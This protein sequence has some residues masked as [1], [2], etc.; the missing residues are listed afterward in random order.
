MGLLGNLFSG[1]KRFASVLIGT[2]N[3][4]FKLYGVTQPNDAQKLKASFYLCVSGIAILNDA[5][6]GAVPHVIDR[7]VEDTRELIKPLSV[8]TE[9]LSNSPEQLGEILSQLPDGVTG[10]T[11]L[12]G[13]AA[14]EAMYFSL[15]Q[16]LM[17][18][19][20]SHNQGPTGTPGYAGIVVVD[21][22][23]G[24]GKSRENFMELSM[25][26]LQFTQG[27]VKAI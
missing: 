6:G 24:D 25:Q 18:D 5:G 22:V 19:I 23:L 4:I 26:M 8:F 12:N 21:G 2:Q 20:L 11:K 16:D 27:L 7:L 13:L 1:K 14:F 9:D 10:S 15:G 3:E 17:N